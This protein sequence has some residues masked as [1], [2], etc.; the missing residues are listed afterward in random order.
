MR[1]ELESMSK[2]LELRIQ[3][4]SHRPELADIC[5]VS[6]VQGML[7]MMDWLM[8]GGE[9]PVSMQVFQKSV[10]AKCIAS[11]KLN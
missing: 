9:N 3:S 6:T 8:E 10:V 1:N 4:K 11:A 2:T 5:M 7:S